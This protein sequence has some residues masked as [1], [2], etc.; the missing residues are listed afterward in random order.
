VF[1]I[2]G[3]AWEWPLKPIAGTTI[4]RSV[5]I[6]LLVLPLSALLAALLYQ[7]TNAALYYLIGMIVYFWAYSE[8]EV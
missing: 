3:F 8:G 2:I 6:R 5:E 4:H 1:G 7:A